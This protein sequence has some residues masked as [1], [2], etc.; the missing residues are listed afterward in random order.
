MDFNENIKKAVKQQ[1]DFFEATYKSAVI[2]H[3]HVEQ[4][5]TSVLEQAKIPTEGLMMFKD[6]FNECNKNRD[7]MKKSI[8]D[9]YD[10]IQTFFK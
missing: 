4:L 3:G 9:S 8:D 6:A 7:T 10:S 2:A 1:K 5:T